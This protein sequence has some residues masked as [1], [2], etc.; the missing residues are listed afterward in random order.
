MIDG[1]TLMPA[2]LAAITNGDSAA[3][4]VDLKRLGSF[5]GTRSPTMK[6]ERTI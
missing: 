6:I 5:D 3:V 4:P 1:T 2:N